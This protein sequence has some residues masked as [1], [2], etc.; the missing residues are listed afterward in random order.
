MNID[1][2]VSIEREYLKA[3]LAWL[4]ARLEREV[5][6]WQLAGQDPADRFRGL[7]VTDS[8]ALA[9][10]RQGP[11]SHWGTG[12]S[13]PGEEEDRITAAEQNAAARIQALGGRG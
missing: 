8:Q 10:T 2:S 5:R 11:G 7:Y 4:D 13:L 9:I 12:I 1:P 3:V 6:S